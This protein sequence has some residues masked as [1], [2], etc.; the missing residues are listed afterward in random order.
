M[1]NKLFLLCHKADLRFVEAPTKGMAQILSYGEVSGRRISILEFVVHPSET[2][3]RASIRQLL[4]YHKQR[5]GSD[6]VV[7]PQDLDEFVTHILS[8][9][10]KGSTT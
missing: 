1:T 3:V 4:K 9:I 7:E 5:T 2:Q 8:T 6:I 10:T